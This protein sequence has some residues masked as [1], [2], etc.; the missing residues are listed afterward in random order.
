V[1]SIEEF[2]SRLEGVKKV[3][4]ES[5]MALC[6]A[7]DDKNPSLSIQLADDRIL[8]H[9]FAGCSPQTIVRALGLEMKD[10]F[11]KEEEPF[12]T[13]PGCATTF[14]EKRERPSDNKPTTLRPG[15]GEGG[16]EP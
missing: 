16:K 4:N 1:T 5:W 11:L 14:L 13:G 12:E 15:L 3:S 8:I 7:H 6:P 2:L 9:C 10:L